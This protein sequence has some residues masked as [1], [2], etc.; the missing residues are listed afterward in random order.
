VKKQFTLATL[1]VIAFIGI[2]GV[3]Q[4]PD[5]AP[6]ITRDPHFVDMYV[7]DFTMVSMNEKG[8]PYFTLE[9]VLMEHFN[10]TGES[11]IT[12]PIFNID[13]DDSAW[14]ISARRG[15]IDDE[16][17]W[18]TLNDDVIMLQ[19]DAENPLELK[20]SKMRFNTKTQVANTDRPVNI[21][22]GTLSLKSNGMIF[23]NMSG[24]LE[25]LAGVNGTYVKN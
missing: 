20:T 19:K 14:V 1:I 15:T 12:A 25:L 11:E 6:V 10:D 7:K 23:N 5:E 22:Q 24:K 9:A 4:A 21:K 16:N 2:W 3:I 8:L 13:R 17:I 18:V